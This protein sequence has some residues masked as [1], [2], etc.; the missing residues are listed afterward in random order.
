MDKYCVLSF[1]VAEKFV[2]VGRIPFVFFE[3]RL[4][5]RYILRGLCV[6]EFL[7]LWFVA[8]S[9]IYSGRGLTLQP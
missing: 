9:F 3:P 8:I 5:D 1:I 6:Y 4:R 2:S 7:M